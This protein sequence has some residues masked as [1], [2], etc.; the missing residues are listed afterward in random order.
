M[1]P[2]QALGQRVGPQSDIFSC[3]S[4]LYEALSGKRAFDGETPMRVLQAVVKCDFTP[5]D[6]VRPDL[7]R[8][9]VKVV[10]RCLR[11][12][13]LQRFSDCGEL[14]RVMAEQK[15]YLRHSQMGLPPV[16]RDDNANRSQKLATRIIIAAVSFA[17]GMAAGL[18]LN[19]LVFS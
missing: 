1:A 14:G 6:Q 4:V 18:I 10:E 3:G 7:P 15:R 13:P 16:T 17:A 8:T 5:L 12:E 9:L 11:S 2:E 19:Q